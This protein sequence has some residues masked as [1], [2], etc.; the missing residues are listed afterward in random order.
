MIQ[1]RIR[2]NPGLFQ[3]LAESAFWHIT[4]VIGDGG[5]FATTLI[6]PDF[7]AAGSLPIECESVDSQH[8]RYFSVSKSR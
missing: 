2:L 8:F 4:I 1:E 5:I 7:M 3:D 6:K